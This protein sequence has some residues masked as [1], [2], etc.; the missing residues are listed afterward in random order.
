MLRTPLVT[1]DRLMHFRGLS[2]RLSREEDDLLD[3][4]QSKILFRAEV[5]REIDLLEE[6]LEKYK[7]DHSPEPVGFFGWMR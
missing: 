2:W 1:A 6:R 4:I 7:K 3:E 5:D